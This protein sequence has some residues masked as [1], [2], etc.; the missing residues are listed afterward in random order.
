MTGPENLSERQNRVTHVIGVSAAAED[1][2]HV[3]LSRV[4]S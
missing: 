3:I 1:P 4:Q 2:G